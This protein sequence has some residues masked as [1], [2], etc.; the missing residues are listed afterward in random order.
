MKNFSK[1]INFCVFGLLM[2]SVSGQTKFQ[3]NGAVS[4]KIDFELV[5]N[6][7]VLP[8]EIN[9]VTLSFLL[10]TGVSKPILFNLTDKDSIS[11]KNTETF[12]LQGLGADGKIEALKSRN[13]SFKLGNASKV[14]QDVYVVFDYDINFTSR[15][16]TLIHGIIGYDVFKDYIVEI[17]Y[18]S[19]YIRLHKHNTFKIKSTKKWQTLPIVIHNKKPYIDIKTQ[20]ESEKTA[21]RLLIDTGSSD[22]LWIFEDKTK[23]LTPPKDLFFN[24]YLG[25]GLSGSVYGKRSKV[26][27]FEMGIFKL[28]NANVAFPDSL[29]IDATKLYQARNGS[30][31]G[32]ILKRFNAFFDFKNEILYLKKNGLFKNKFTY[33]NS[34]LVIEHNGMM[35]VKERIKLPSTDGY[36]RK[37][38]NAI[39]VDVSI[40]YRMALK[41]A[42]RIVEIRTSSN[43]YAAGLQ[44]GDILININGK[45]AYEYQLTEINKILHSQTG[46][47][48]KVTIERNG[49]NKTY[50]FKLDSAFKKNEPSK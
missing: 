44:V 4:D 32:E 20:I 45:P 39:Q 24:D 14:N 15:L 3:F 28:Q 42:Y 50:K 30:L 7:I 40:N 11:L 8:V 33:N 46:R 36:G 35:F 18:S 38:D 26:K 25:K 22:A 23:G 47:T 13:N 37:T 31:G 9:G 17:N 19:K 2:F 29:S 21:L 6:L 12:Y 41:P 34:G 5:S 1:Y 48:I 43:A 27:V 16:G 10:D 49:I